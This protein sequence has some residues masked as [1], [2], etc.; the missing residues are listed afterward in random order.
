ME[1]R[2]YELP[3][4]LSALTANGAPGSPRPISLAELLSTG[5]LRRSKYSEGVSSDEAPAYHD[6]LRHP[7][8]PDHTTIHTHPIPP[9]PGR[10]NNIGDRMILNTSLPIHGSREIPYEFAYVL[11]AA[12]HSAKERTRRTDMNGIVAHAKTPSCTWYRIRH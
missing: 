8:R 3:D 9:S 1:L 7:K 12:N 2:V 11:A 6:T 4:E 10:G 5:I